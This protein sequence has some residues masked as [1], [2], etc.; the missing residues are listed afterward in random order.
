MDVRRTTLVSQA[1]S[2]V[3][4]APALLDGLEAGFEVGEV[5]HGGIVARPDICFYK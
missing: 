4:R 5:G 1:L 3:T 2:A